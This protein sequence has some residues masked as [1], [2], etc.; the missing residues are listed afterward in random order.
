MEFLK[1]YFRELV[2]ILYDMSPWLILG[3]LIAGVLHIFFPDGKIR[4]I[5]GRSNTGSVVNAALLGVPMPLCSC[6]VIPTGVSFYRSGAS[7]GSA[8]SFLISTPQTGVDSILITYSMLGLPLA[9][10][11]PLVAFITGI[12]GGFVSNFLEKKNRQEKTMSEVS[13]K[14]NNHRGNL[15]WEVLRY[16]FGTFLMD[17]AKWIVIGLLIAALIAVAVP[18]DFF[19]AYIKSDFLGMLIILAASIPVYVCATSSV[20]IAAVLMLKGISPGAALVFL[21]AGPATNAATITVIGKVMGRRTL[22]TYLVSIM[23]GALFFGLL[24]D[25]VLPREMF[26][27]ALHMTHTVHE[28]GLLPLWLKMSSGIILSALIIFGYLRKT[29]IRHKKS[30]KEFTNINKPT[31][32]KELKLIVKGMTCRHCK[33][34]V[35]NSINAIKGIHDSTADFETGEVTVHGEYIDMKKIRD[36]VENAGYAFQGIKN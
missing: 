22:M 29:M 10:L 18:D 17:I 8:V 30:K 13:Q 35:E 12:A 32:M 25:Y 7:K 34:S 9:V 33:M 20:P 5:L 19:A 21:M 16:S 24:I 27:N 6:G 15:L 2:S 14:S 11:R 1:S 31:E 3:F 36:A 26:L 23:T 28:H 4:K